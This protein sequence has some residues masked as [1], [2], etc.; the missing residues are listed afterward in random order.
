MVSADLGAYWRASGGSRLILRVTAA[1]VMVLP[2]VSGTL[3]S[4]TYGLR[5]PTSLKN[6]L[7]DSILTPCISRNYFMEK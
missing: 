3:I 2:Q 5:G 4:G 1:G 6:E 7:S